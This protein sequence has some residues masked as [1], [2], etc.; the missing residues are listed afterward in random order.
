MRAQLPERHARFARVVAPLWN[1]PGGWSIQSDPTVTHRH[2]KGHAAHQ[3][4]GQRG[5][6]EPGV[7]ILSRSVP[8]TDN[9]VVANHQERLGIPDGQSFPQG[10]EFGGGEALTFGR[11]AVPKVTSV[12]QGLGRQLENKYEEWLERP[13]HCLAA[14]HSAIKAAAQARRKYSSKAQSPL[15]PV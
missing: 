5:C 6:A 14:V 11:P 1:E 7:G 2:R 8:L 15:L 12:K 4:F 13:V 10:L 9:G 3:R